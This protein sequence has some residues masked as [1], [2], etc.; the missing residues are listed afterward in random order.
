LRGCEARE[1]KSAAQRDPHEYSTKQRPLT[2]HRRG[3]LC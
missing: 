3:S 2:P 1:Q